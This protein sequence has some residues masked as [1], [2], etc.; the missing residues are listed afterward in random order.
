MMDQPRILVVDDEE[1]VRA[2][3]CYVLDTTGYAWS[4]AANGHDAWREFTQGAFDLVILDVML[5]DAS[6]IELCR[7]I[8]TQSS[9]PII[10]LSALSD[11]ENRI[12]GLEAGADDYITKPFSPREVGLRV[13]A[14][15]RRQFGMMAVIEGEG[16]SANM[17]TGEI[18]FRGETLTL[19][20]MEIRVLATLLR[21]LNRTVTFSH[22]LSSVWQTDETIGGREMVRIT[23]HRLRAHLRELGVRNDLIESVRGSGY[24]IRERT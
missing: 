20:S 24:R 3:V 14:I 21:S 11:E 23:I 4:E 1:Q 6:G 15:V 18:M 16:I 7:R 10:V 9:V 2:I 17:E 22:L 12:A 19:P 5:P 8:R 13:D